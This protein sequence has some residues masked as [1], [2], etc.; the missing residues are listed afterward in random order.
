MNEK[1]VKLL[2]YF[3]KH[4]RD[5]QLAGAAKVKWDTLDHKKKGKLT[6]WLKRVIVTM[7]TVEKAQKARKIEAIKASNKNVLDNFFGVPKLVDQ[8][9]KALT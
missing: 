2:R 9:G 1:Q 3:A 6:K 8:Y 7:M 4:T 5:L